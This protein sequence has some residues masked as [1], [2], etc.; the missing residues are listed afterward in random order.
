MANKIITVAN[1][2]V[3]EDSGV[4]A[5]GTGIDLFRRQFGVWEIT[6]DEGIKYT[7]NVHPI[8]TIEYSEIEIIDDHFWGDSPSGR[9]TKQT[10]T[11]HGED[12]VVDAYGNISPDQTWRD[13]LSSYLWNITDSPSVDWPSP[14][15]KFIDY[16]ATIESNLTTEES[17]NMDIDNLEAPSGVD[18]VYNYLDIDYEQLL[19]TVSNHNL[20]PSMNEMLKETYKS[21]VYEDDIIGSGLAWEENALQGSTADALQRNIDTQ[22]DTNRFTNQLLPSENNG[23]LKDYEVNKYLFPMYTQINIPHT[24]K[25]EIS[26]AIGESLAGC[27]LSRDV[28]GWYEFPPETVIEETLNYSYTYESNGEWIVDSR[29][30]ASK[31]VDLEQWILNDLP[32]YSTEFPHQPPAGTVHG[33]AGEPYEPKSTDEALAAEIGPTADTAPLAGAPDPW[34]DWVYIGI[35]TDSSILANGGDTIG[36]ATAVSALQTNLNGIAANHRRTF[37]DLIEGTPS[38][39]ET[40]MYKVTK[41]LGEGIDSPIQTFYF[42]NSMEL[43]SFMSEES[44]ISFVDTQVKYNQMYTYSVIAYQAIIGAKYI[45]S[46]LQVGIAGGAGVAYVDVEMSPLIKIVEMP[47]FISVGRILSSPPLSPEINFIPYRGIPDQILFHFN[48]ALGSEDLEPITFTAQEADDISQV[49]FNQKRTDGKITFETDDHNIAF[50]IYRVDK[51]PVSYSDFSESLLAIASTNSTDP[52]VNLQ[53]GSTSAL[54]K[55]TTNKKY[56]YMFRSVDLH[57]GLSNPSEV[58]EIELYNDGGVG[59][60]IIRQYEFGSADPKTTTKSARKLIQIIPR[61]SQAYLNEEASGLVNVDGSLSSAA[62][63]SISLGLEDESLFATTAGWGVATGKRFKIRLT[64]KFTGKKVDI[65]VDFKTN[66]IQ[67]E[68]E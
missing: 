17:L 19:N 22:I 55:Q 9:R 65:N 34:S 59:Y 67:G 56:Y 18:Y 6:S 45:Y 3:V 49:S 43:K 63:K 1:P 30:A 62:G 33:S 64:S 46:N 50:Q 32:A 36:V 14:E 53:A 10:I 4:T 41:F 51:P 31:T 38:Y 7:P 68:I 2:D 39:S 61:I 11:I 12:V 47:L 29:P 15:G 5:M 24:S 54:I 23:L 48:T 44:R 57:G 27:A 28:H 26:Y 35:D 8:F 21:G 40:L 66:R 42:M 60:P 52:Q 58:Y 20:I 16:V 25:T 13:Y 37:Q